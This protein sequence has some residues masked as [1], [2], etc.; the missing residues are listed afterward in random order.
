M[1]LLLIACLFALLTPVRADGWDDFSNNLATDLAPF[2]A[3]FGEQTTKQYLS[4]S[5]TVLDYYIFSIAP[6]GIL[7][8]VISAI[9]VC[10]SPS[11]R[12]F[13]GRAQEGG[14]DAEAEL[15]SSTSRDVCELYN[16]GGIA[17]V[18][19]RPKILEVVYDP[20]KSTEETAGIYPC[21]EFVK[22]RPDEWTR[23]DESALDM[24]IA[25]ETVADIFAPNL[26][27]NI[28]I[29]RQSTVV[30]W[31]VAV[32]GTLL[33]VGVLAFAVV[34]TYCLKWEKDGQRPDS[35]ACP[36]AIVGTLIEW[37]GMFLCAFLVGKTS[38]KQVFQRNRQ[39]LDKQSTLDV[40]PTN[41][42]IFWVQPG[43][44]VLGDQVFDPF[45]HSDHDQPLLQYVTSWKQSSKGSDSEL[46]LWA[47]VSTTIIGFVL[48][49]VGLRGIHSAVSV[50]QLGA[51]MLMSM[52]RSAL[53]M[54]RLK[55][56]DNFLRQC[57]DEVVGHELDWLAMRIGRQDALPGSP[58]RLLWRFC[59]A[60]DNTYKIT[61]ERPSMGDDLDIAGKLL[62]YRT[63]LAQLTQSKTTQA[64]AATPSQ[65]FDSEMVQVR[66]I[67]QRLALAIE[68]TVNKIFSRSS[69]FQE[70]WRDHTSMFWSFACDVV[71][72]APNESCK[73]LSQQTLYL[74][75]TRGNLENSWKFQ[76]KLELEGILGLW[77][78]SLKSD[79][80]VEILQGPFTVSRATEIPT[81]RIVSTKK[82]IK[83]TGLQI[84][85]GNEMPISFD[86]MS[87]SAASERCDPST[88][89]YQDKETRFFGWHAADP[90]QRQG[91][92]PFEV[93]SAPTNSSLP[94]LC[95][96][97][98]FGSFIVS[99]FDTVNLAED[100]GIQEDP[101]VRLES[102]LVSEIITLF[103]EAQL[104]SREDALLC[105][106]PPMTSRLKMPSAKTVLAIAKRRANEHRRRGQWIKAEVMLKWAW[107]IC[108]QSQPQSHEGSG[109][110]NHAS[111][112][113]DNLMQ[114]AAIAL[115]E[116]YRWAMTT[117]EMR[118]FSSDGIKWLSAQKSS[119][120]QS[121]STAV[122]EIIDRYIDIEH[123]VDHQVDN[124]GDDL[125]STLSRLT[126]PASQILMLT[127]EKSKALCSAAALGW[128]EVAITMLE[129]G[130]NPDYKDD[131]RR[132]RTA[133][134]LAAESN[135]VDVVEELI[136]WGASPDLADDYGRTP[137]SHA[138]GMGHDIVVKMLLDDPRVD[139]STTD[140]WGET[141]LTMAMWGKH[142][143][144][145]QLLLDS[146]RIDINAKNRF[147]KTPLSLAAR[148][149]QTTFVQML[150]NTG[151]AD[152]DAEDE[153]G[154]TPL[155]YA[156]ENGH[157]EIVELLRKHL[158]PR[159]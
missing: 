88:I 53:R 119:R 97:E 56:D 68:S 85:L 54:Q 7:T 142:E 15:C 103:T 134:S 158:P 95:A 49:F 71:S 30:S 43:G 36:M 83:E 156:E 32:S 159:T 57:P 11:L 16:N 3:L 69:K 130:A 63:R 154:K 127:E 123:R 22:T 149:G 51:M 18:F 17:R 65:Q 116:L 70:E 120:G 60:R 86:F 20:S 39:A 108:N 125:I 19:G 131:N 145:F 64:W 91:S 107:D 77:A 147:L 138:S 28:G 58:R 143:G 35:Y 25:D 113:T 66:E 157:Q 76:N 82:N 75:L 115:G 42:S 136:H 110:Q 99:I 34:V 124:S 155:L 74:Q 114:E 29:K 2:L 90:S 128:S 84:W 151:R 141:P 135:S 23:H 98:V 62:A 31:V 96:Q 104:G 146:N 139:P 37:A 87:L 9:R 89:R 45:C 150:L 6:I 105:I 101:Y 100:V 109:S 129:L 121:I 38:R 133:I 132:F 4:E 73:P 153:T 67:S 27:L 24:P 33:Q 112:L 80:E 5:I 72:A 144:V 40:Q 126:V 122:G 79:P 50:A 93:W 10:G 106:L 48:Q 47:A 61:K 59:G 111:A 44:Q 81:R 92:S 78:W 152:L 117:N 21:R 26:S 41:S 118:K 8:A 14:G 46:A 94:S 137:L 55:P 12:A 148:D 140:S 13:I 1:N 52:V 102:S